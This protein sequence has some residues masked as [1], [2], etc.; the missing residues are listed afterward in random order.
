MTGAR[1]LVLED[2][3]LAARA[4]IHVLEL[5]GYCCQGVATAFDA[6]ERLPL[7]DPEIVLYEWSL[8]AES[9]VGLARRMRL[10]KPKLFIVALSAA[11]EPIG[12]CRDEGID[13]YL[14]KPFSFV[15][16][17]ALLATRPMQ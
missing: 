15:D 1:V 12:F 16:L 17:Q 10:V 6:L 11:D 5:R 13:G 9:G 7:F 8:F 2:N 14:T 4:L 3:D